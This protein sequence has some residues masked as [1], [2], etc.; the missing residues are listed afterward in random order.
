MLNKLIKHLTAGDDPQGSYVLGSILKTSG[1]SPQV[2]GAAAIFSGKEIVAGTLGGGVLEFESQAKAA[3][4]SENDSAT[5]FTYELN[6]DIA[7]ADGAICGGKVLVLLDPGCSGD[8]ELFATIGRSLSAGQWGVLVS[9]ISG[10]SNEKV[11][12][13]RKWYPGDNME[14]LVAGSDI[15]GFEALVNGAIDSRNPLLLEKDDRLIFVEPLNPTPE[16]VI[17]G[18]GHIGQSLAHIGAL[19]D[20]N[21]TV[22][23]DREGYAN[24]ERFPDAAGIIVGDLEEAVKALRITDN[25]YIVIMTT[26]HT[27]DA[28]AL[29]H[30]IASGA[31]YI[32]MIGSK[33]K[34]SLI[35][36]RFL[37]MGWAT[38]DQFDR[39][40]APIGLPIPSKTV[41]EI[42]ISIAAELIVTR[43]ESD[44]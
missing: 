32:G 18:A 5:L 36:N 25:T 22:I 20:F 8:S 39:V 42:A 26:T 34:I 17:V 24:K 3:K 37:E 11:V 7:K 13:E 14:S 28:K 43:K 10:I 33:R 1:S 21:V 44:G 9:S 4:M 41:A 19:L 30:C 31:A 12:V 27:G 40:H 29:R 35:R 2:P 6:S 38:E 23:D 16:L 15:H